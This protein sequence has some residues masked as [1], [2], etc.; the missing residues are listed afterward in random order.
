MSWESSTSPSCEK[1]CSSRWTARCPATSF[2]SNVSE[3]TIGKHLQRCYRKLGAA[4]R[5]GA[6]AT[7]VWDD[8]AARGAGVGP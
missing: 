6:A 1:G 8:G 5:S 4:N 7:V 2:R 3:R